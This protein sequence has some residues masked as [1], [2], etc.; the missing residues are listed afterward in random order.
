MRGGSPPAR[1]PGGLPHGKLC[2]TVFAVGF[3][4]PARGAGQVRRPL[5]G[6]LRLPV[7][8]R[9]VG[10]V[11]PDAARG[12]PNLRGPLRCQTP[13]TAAHPAKPPV[14]HGK[15]ANRRELWRRTWASGCSS[16]PAAV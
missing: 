5:T 3:W 7:G 1:L 13:R 15:S 12:N 11:P 16:N 4:V 14:H 9:D 10:S 6:E 8:K 2:R